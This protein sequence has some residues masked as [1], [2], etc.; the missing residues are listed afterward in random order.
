[1]VDTAKD[2]TANQTLQ[3]TVTHSVS[4]VNVKTVVKHTNVELISS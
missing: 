3:V 2:T 4:D 1:M